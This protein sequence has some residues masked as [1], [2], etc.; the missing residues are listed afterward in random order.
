MRARDSIGAGASGSKEFR[1]FSN[2]VCRSGVC[3]RAESPLIA[4]AKPTEKRTPKTVI[5]PVNCRAIY[6]TYVYVMAVVRGFRTYPIEE[7][8]LA[9]ELPPPPPPLLLFLLHTVTYLSCNV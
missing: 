1:V 9:I 4:V 2:M 8:S 7:D 3:R 5:I 6:V